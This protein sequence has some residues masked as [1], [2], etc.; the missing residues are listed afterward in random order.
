MYDD[1]TV[2]FPV[3]RPGMMI[4]VV[5]GYPCFLPFATIFLVQKSTSAARSDPALQRDLYA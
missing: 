1:G 4:A 2:F 3:T 5:N